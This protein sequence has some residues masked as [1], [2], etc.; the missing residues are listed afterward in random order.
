MVG[1][2]HSPNAD[3]LRP[4]S[5]SEAQECPS[6]QAVHLVS[7]IYY[8]S[9]TAQGLILENRCSELFPKPEPKPRMEILRERVLQEYTPMDAQAQRE[10]KIQQATQRLA[11]EEKEAL[12]AFELAE[13]AGVLEE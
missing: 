9:C 5:C 11:D 1:P 12:C 2:W 6:F 8:I 13:Q 4:R 10:Q 3:L 7:W